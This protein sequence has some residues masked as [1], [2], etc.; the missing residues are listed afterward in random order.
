M[1]NPVVRARKAVRT[2]WHAWEYAGWVTTQ[3]VGAPFAKSDLLQKLRIGLRSR[4]DIFSRAYE[5]ASWGSQESG[6]G[7]GSELMA[8]EAVRANLAPLLG[9]HNI[10]ALLDAPC[11]DWNWMQHVDLS[12]I[13]Y[14]GVD[15]VPAVVAANRKK[16]QRSNVS[17]L[18]A[19]LTEDELPRSEAILCRDCLIHT[20]YQDIS[21]ILANF[22]RT[23][24][25]WLL[26]NTYPDVSKNRNQFTGRSWRRLTL[27][28]RPSISFTNRNTVGWRRW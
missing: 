1:G 11:G 10:G 5:N 12:G 9:W 17:F 16:Y 3:H 28:C 27:S 18:V 20:S 25:T 23:G 21:A 19:D 13:E 7:V 4:S 14:W 22:K 26:L 15:I 6:S 24:A 2:A 8:T